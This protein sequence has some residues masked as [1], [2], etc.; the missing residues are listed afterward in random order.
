M[1]DVDR[2]PVWPTRDDAPRYAA[3]GVVKRFAKQPVLKGVDFELRGGQVHAL[4]GENGS[5]KST[6]IKIMSGALRPS[7]GHLEFDG[8]RVELRS[9]L[10]ARSLGLAVVHQDHQLFP[11]LDVAMNISGTTL[12]PGG[13]LPGSVSH[14]GIRDRAR[15]LLEQLGIEMDVS[16]RVRELSP[17]DWKLIEIARSLSL[18]PRFMILDEPTASLDRHDSRR[19]LTLIQRLSARG[20]GVGFVS[21][22]L[23]EALEVSHWVTVLRDGNLVATRP[24]EHLSLRGL[25]RL[26][27]GGDFA[28]DAKLAPTVAGQRDAVVALRG[29]SVRAGAAPF[30]LDVRA[31]EILG[32]TGL[33][34][35]GALEVA[36]MMGGRRRLPGSV[37]V[38]GATRVLRRPRDA[39]ALGIGYIPE[40]RQHDGLV[41]LLSVAV[42][43][44]LATL[45]AISPRTIVSRRRLRV[46][47]AKYVEALNIKAPSVDAP[48]G[49][50]S[51][52]NQQK[53]L[54]GRWLAT[55]SRVLIVETP[56]HGVDVGAKGEIVRLLRRFAADGGA[57]VVASTDVS[58]VLATADRVAVFNHGELVH[59]FDA[60]ETSYGKILVE[61]AKNKQ[62]QEVETRLE[63]DRETYDSRSA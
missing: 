44:S 16:R 61:G 36:R 34:G 27:V 3:V 18:D 4:I 14:R 24:A 1:T 43:L 22:R 50:L 9:P 48:V 59:V 56:T 5:G 35:A 55:G 11:D 2:A 12:A 33:V 46:H 53:V 40:D 28:E 57:V 52:G 7:E 31:G 32:L 58:E 19:V 15:E 20:V 6:L 42:N 29:V 47:A 38:D 30:D 63:T 54:I 8:Q 49:S 17:A 10:A 41:G 60:S 25:A 23:E 39:H 21:H 37:L 13:R 26:I 62:L 45:P 51:G